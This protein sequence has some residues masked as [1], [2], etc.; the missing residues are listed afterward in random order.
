MAFE[1][2]FNL[3]IADDKAGEI[4]TVGDAIEH[5]ERIKK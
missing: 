5:L 3:E 2:E 1:E 4:L